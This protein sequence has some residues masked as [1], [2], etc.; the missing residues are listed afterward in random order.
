MIAEYCADLYGPAQAEMKAFIAYSEAHWNDMLTKPDSITE[1][2]ALLAKALAKAPAG[3]FY[4]KRI[5][6]V[7]DYIQPLIARRDQILRNAERENAR[8]VRISDRD[9]SKIAIDGRLDEEVWK[10]LSGYQQGNLLDCT[11]GKDTPKMKS[12]MGFFWHNN[13]IY[14]GIR[15][16]DPDMKNLK[17]TGTQNDDP[18]ILGGDHVQLLIETQTHGFYQLAINPAGL[19]LDMDHQGGA[20][21]A[22]SSG[23]SIA[24][25]TGDGFWSVEIRLPV[26]GD[27][28]G[29]V[30]P[31]NGITG[32]KPAG[33]Y[34]WYFNIC[35]QRIRDGKTERFAFSPT[36][37]PDFLDPA[38]FG[39]MNGYLPR[40][41]A[42]EDEKRKRADAKKAP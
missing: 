40:G 15:C 18:H 38:K 28:Q 7:A 37:K 16:D 23:A 3:S 32:R 8:T 1:T 4:A 41:T 34:P 9:G 17:V 22:W 11:T 14:L 35:R 20:K 5:A 12:H 10:K 24:T 2:F 42:W 29:D 27:L 21:P 26:P 19:V 31:L 36:D 33:T 6:L 30:D 25:Y 39:R 13:S